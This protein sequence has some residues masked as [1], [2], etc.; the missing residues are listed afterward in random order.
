MHRRWNS[1]RSTQ[2]FR[3]SPTKACDRRL[4]RFEQVLRRLWRSHEEGFSLVELLIGSIVLI[5]AMG[6]VVTV[7]KVSQGLHST[8]QEGLELAQNVSSALNFIS[9]ELVNAGSGVPYLT[10]NNGSSEILVPPGALMASLGGA[11]SSDTD[12]I[13]FVTPA[14]QQG[15]TVTMDGEGN[16]L[17]HSIQ[18]DMLVFLGGTGNAGF[19]NQSPPGPSANWGQT[20]YV[21]NSAMFSAGQVVLISNGFQVS[22]G[23]ITKVNHDGGLVFNNGQDALKLNPGS[24]AQVPNP[25]MSSAQQI[26]GGPPSQVFPLAA[27]TYFIDA[28]TDPVHPSIK[29]LANSNAGAAGATTLADDIENLSVVFLVDDDSNATTPAVDKS[30]PTTPLSL[31]RGVKVTITGRSHVKTGDAAWPDGHSRLTLSQT[32]FFRNNIAR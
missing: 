26:T 24:T 23:Q 10:K 28:T 13:Y 5:G 21:E 30:D 2:L 22:L 1:V 11:L 32:V 7:L 19:V 29:R 25:N 6:A 18:T 17:A 27:I 20:V 16:P 3:I 8:S 12:S 9:S 4:K 31:V 15:Q 14:Y